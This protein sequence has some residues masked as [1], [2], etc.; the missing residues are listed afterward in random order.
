MIVKYCRLEL[1]YDCD[2]QGEEQ[3]GKLTHTGK[4]RVRQGLYFDM[5]SPGSVIW[6]QHQIDWV[7]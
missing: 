6:R 5:G 3:S 7:T 1:K 2:T 4:E